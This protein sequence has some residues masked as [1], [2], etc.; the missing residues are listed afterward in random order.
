[1]PDEWSTVPTE[2]EIWI[3]G[4]LSPERAEW[5]GNMDLT[6]RR[7]AGGGPITVLSG[8]VTD[9]AALFGILN[10]IRDL[11]LAL[12]AVNPAVPASQNAPGDDRQQ[13][14]DAC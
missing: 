1:M 5:F 6:V 10:R 3:S 2:Y 8:T 11:G 9:R 14:E 4:H 12:I 7:A 13:A